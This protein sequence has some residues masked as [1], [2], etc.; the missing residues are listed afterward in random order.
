MKEIGARI[1][2]ARK[3]MKLSQ[4]ELAE[5][6]SISPSHMSDI[7]NGK[8]IVKLDIFM[9]LTEALQVSA[10]WLL[11]TDVPQVASIHTQELSTILGDCTP[12][13]AQSIIKMA[14][15]MKTAIRESAGK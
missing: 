15:E 6:V 2:Q 9:R 4:N 13:E 8:K 5:M 7:E 11:R 3:A 10:D 14:K 12:S 1:R